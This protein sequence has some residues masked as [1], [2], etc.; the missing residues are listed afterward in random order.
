MTLKAYGAKRLRQTIQADINKAHYFATLLDDAGD[1]ERMAPVPL[2][3]V[4][5]RY[6][7]DGFTE[8]EIEKLNRKLIQAIEKDG[9]IFLT[10]TRIDGK[11]ALRTCFIN[12]RTTREDLQLILE[13]IR[14]LG[15]K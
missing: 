10:G 9:R 7:P 14:N 15:R 1:F 4:C 13:V 11:T 8:K 5:F 12:P 6:T 3:I 2:S